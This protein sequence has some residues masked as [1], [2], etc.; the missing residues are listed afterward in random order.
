MSQEIQI[1]SDDD[2]DVVLSS[3]VMHIYIYIYMYLLLYV[4]Y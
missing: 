1:N 3:Y 4:P 2:Q